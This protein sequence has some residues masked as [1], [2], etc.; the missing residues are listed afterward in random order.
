[1]PDEGQGRSR[2]RLP[3]WEPVGED[4]VDLVF[5][6]GSRISMRDRER[7]AATQDGLRCRGCGG[8]VGYPKQHFSE[9]T[10]SWWCGEDA[11]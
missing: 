8:L 1:M 11:R 5:P 10:R 9:D 6:N 3:R 4:Q 2:M 7:V